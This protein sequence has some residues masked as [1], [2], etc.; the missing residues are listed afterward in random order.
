M[1]T[2]CFSFGD[3]NIMEQ[4]PYSNGGL[5]GMCVAVSS[6]DSSRAVKFNNVNMPYLNCTDAV[7]RSPMDQLPVHLLQGV[8]LPAPA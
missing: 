7:S 2:E 6:G 4:R 3:S 1:T 5:E 8:P